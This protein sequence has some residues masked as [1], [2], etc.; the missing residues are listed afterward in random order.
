MDRDAERLSLGVLQSFTKSIVGKSKLNN[1]NWFNTGEGRFFDSRLLKYDD[2]QEFSE[3]L[4]FVPY[5]KFINHLKRILDI[6]GGLYWFAPKFYMHVIDSDAITRMKAGVTSPMSIGFRYPLLVDVKDEK[7]GELLWREYRNSENQEAEALE[8]SHV[9][10]GAQYGASSKFYNVTDENSGCE[11]ESEMPINLK[12]SIGEFTLQAD[13]ENAEFIA[14]VESKVQELEQV[15]TLN[16]SLETQKVEAENAKAKAEDDLAAMTAENNQLDEKIKQIEAEKDS[17][18]SE[19]VEM[20][21]QN[22]FQAGQMK[23][24]EA[25]GK[26]AEL[27]V[28]TPAELTEKHRSLKGKKGAISFE[29][30]PEKPA[31]PNFHDRSFISD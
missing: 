12:M 20:I 9:F 10:L 23:W 7:S 21:L 15:K 4:G 3:T 13:G 2:P 1:H 25:D 8:G 18:K 14:A 26:R 31:L 17:L 5:K 27:M 24:D 29:P 6:E 11:E 19:V 28:L 30:K 22:T 16:Q